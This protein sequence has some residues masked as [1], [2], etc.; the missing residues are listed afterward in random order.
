MFFKAGTDRR[1]RDINE[2][3]EEVIADLSNTKDP[4]I[5]QAL[6]SY[7]IVATHAHTRPFR[8][9]WLNIITGIIL[10]LGLF[11]Y[12]RMWRFRLRLLKD[13][14]QIKQSNDTIIARIEERHK[15]K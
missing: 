5:L 1:I 7:P 4:V 12:L 14:R 15:G 10:P 2:E 6:N 13:L 11:F 3:L 8:Q 9:K